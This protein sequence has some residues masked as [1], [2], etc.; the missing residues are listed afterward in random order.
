MITMA[1]IG[2][3]K[4]TNRYHLPFSQQV[5]GLKIKTIYARHDNSPWPK[6]PGVAYT[7]NIDDI[8]NDPEVTLVA[9]TTPPAAHYE[10]AMA[11]LTH[12][13]NVLL[14]K[15]FTET[16]AQAKELF[17]FAK[18]QGLL[19]EGYQNRRFDSDFLTVQKVIESGKLGQVYE[20]ENNFDYY[21]PQS[22][23]QSTG[24]SRLGSFY[25]VTPCTQWIKCCHTGV[26]QSPFSMTCIRCWGRAMM[27][28]T[29]ILICII[30]RA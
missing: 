5:A 21:R 28:I 16:A 25:T 22:S 12:G 30:P 17:A 4:A 7:T 19:L 9:I 10:L 1:Y 11:A 15:P 18:K 2:N 24:Y 27:P 23:E 29:S 13:K 3:G 26:L 20:V 6:Q 8:W 14:E